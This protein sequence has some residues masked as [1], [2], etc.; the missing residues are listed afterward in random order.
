VGRGT[1]TILDDDAT[2]AV[3]VAAFAALAEPAA[4]IGGP[5]KRR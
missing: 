5:I 3:K 1:G 2:A 4:P